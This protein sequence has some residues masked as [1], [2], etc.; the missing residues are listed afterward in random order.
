M[1]RRSPEEQAASPGLTGQLGIAA[2]AGDD[3]ASQKEQ[4]ASL[5]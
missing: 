1:D 4:R 5:V 3:E 2:E